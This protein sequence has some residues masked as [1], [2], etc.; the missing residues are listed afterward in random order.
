MTS[1]TL[2]KR[3]KPE[4]AD[5]EEEKKPEIIEAP[6]AK[7]LKQ[8]EAYKS[9]FKP[10]YEENKDTDFLCRNVHRGLR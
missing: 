9:L 5:D 4:Q 8:S 10:M 3:S 2:G 7:R 1:S 6:E